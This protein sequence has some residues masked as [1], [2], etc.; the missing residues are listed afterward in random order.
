MRTCN[1]KSG[2]LESPEEKQISYLFEKR[3]TLQ[4]LEVDFVGL[5]VYSSIPFKGR[6]FSCWG[7]KK[8]EGFFF[9]SQG[10]LNSNYLF[11]L[12]FPLV[13]V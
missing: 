6:V 12:F 10:F 11:V 2:V 3:A 9:K 5:G 1:R 8:I 7:I 4:E 13:F